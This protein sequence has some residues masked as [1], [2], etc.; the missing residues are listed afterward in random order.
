MPGG[1]I[2]RLTLSAKATTGCFDP[3]EATNDGDRRARALSLRA[4]TVH[5]GRIELGSR[6]ALRAWQA[7]DDDSSDDYSSPPTFTPCRPRAE[8][9]ERGRRTAERAERIGRLRG[10]SLARSCIPEL[11]R[12]RIGSLQR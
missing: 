5:E 12:A 1:F 7:L 11:E 9:T 3:R 6:R 8:P 2:V 10:R 4:A